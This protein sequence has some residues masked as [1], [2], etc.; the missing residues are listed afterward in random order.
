LI[1]VLALMNQMAPPTTNLTTPDPECDLD[2]VP[3]QARAVKIKT[4]VCN[5][6]GFGGHNNVLI[7]RQP[8]GLRNLV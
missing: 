6:F 7:F 5:S 3:N 1:T 8:N 4:A 2:Y